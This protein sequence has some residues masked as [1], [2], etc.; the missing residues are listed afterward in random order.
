M[1]APMDL[2]MLNRLTAI[3]PWLLLWLPLAGLLA[4]WGACAARIPGKR[5]GLLLLFIP[6]LVLAAV[7]F[8]GEWLLG[9]NGLTYRTWLREGLSVVLWVAGLVL[10]IATVRHFHGW[11][12]ENRPKLAAWGMALSL[13]GLVC[14]ML[15]GTVLGGLWAMGP[16]EQVVTYAGEKAVLGTWTWMDTSYEL[17]EYH[18]PLVRGAEP[19]LADWD[20]TLIEGAVNVPW[21][22]PW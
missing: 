22:D 11:L 8:G 12:K 5:R 16:G 21:N 4:M 14:V 2:E 3:L 1:D 18:G 15:F 9:Q 6:A 20:E 13:Y 10:G 17:Y 19:M 7:L